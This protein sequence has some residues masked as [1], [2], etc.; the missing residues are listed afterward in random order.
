M[1]GNRDCTQNGTDEEP[2]QGPKEVQP[3]S[4][5]LLSL[6]TGAIGISPNQPGSLDP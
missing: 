4:A 6:A 1:C 5:Q 2:D 3:E